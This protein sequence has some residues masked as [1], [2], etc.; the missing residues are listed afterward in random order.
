MSECG[1]HIPGCTSP[2][3]CPDASFFNVDNLVG[4][5][6]L[7]YAPVGYYCG[8]G[9][10]KLCPAGF[11]CPDVP[12]ALPIR[13]PEGY[14]C[15]EGF[16]EPI[17][18]PIL[19]RCPEGSS[20]RKPD[21]PAIIILVGIIAGMGLLVWLVT[22]FRLNR[23]GRSQAA[24]HRHKEIKRLFSDLVL[25]ITGTHVASEPLQGFNESIRYTSPVSISFKE[26]AMT[27]KT[28]GSTVL[29]GITGEFPPGSLVAVM[30]GSG[31]GKTT[32]MN[33]LANRAP[34][35]VV[36]GEVCLNG[37]AG[38]TIGKYPRLVGFVPQDD[39]MHDDLTV[40]ENLMYSAR[41]R[42]PPSIPL[43]QQR[44]I[45]EDVISI[46]DLDRIRDTIV[47]S[48]EKRGT[49]SI[50]QGGV[51]LDVSAIVYCSLRED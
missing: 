47:G 38:E 46:L 30:G 50:N 51:C 20:I 39:I 17:E 24:D 34:Y 32:F 5:C 12:S 14:F 44:A 35:G 19:S 29:K 25:G 26:L 18:C 16:A 21:A 43:A 15:L 23:L 42:L 8:Q 36:S 3:L 49:L 10:L 37:V 28:N 2:Q 48:P 27:L 45:V 11:Y 1:I 9:E 41:L 7:C 13:C 6:G 33:A 31:A 22:K 40:Y 4:T